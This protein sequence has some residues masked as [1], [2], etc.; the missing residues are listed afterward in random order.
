MDIIVLSPVQRKKELKHIVKKLEGRGLQV[1]I[2]KGLR[3]TIIGV[4]R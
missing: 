2:S 3:R 1:N 4:I